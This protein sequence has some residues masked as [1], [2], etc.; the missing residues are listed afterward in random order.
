MYITTECNGCEFAYPLVDHVACESF[1]LSDGGGVA[2]LGNTEFGV[3]VPWLMALYKILFNTL[4][5]SPAT[6]LGE[7][8]ASAQR[9]YSDPALLARPM[10]DQRW[11]QFVLVLMGDPSMRVRTQRPMPLTLETQTAQSAAGTLY[12]FQVTSQGIPVP[13]AAVT[14]YAPEAFLYTQRT[15]AQGSATILTPTAPTET[16]VRVSATAVNSIP[17]FASF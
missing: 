11:Q 17:A 15:D 1:L 8:V 14:V 9:E 12:T 7:A 5:T 6:A 13:D 10:L 2:Y 16:A 3:G 4:F